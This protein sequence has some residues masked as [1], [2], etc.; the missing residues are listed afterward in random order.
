MEEVNPAGCMHTRANNREGEG[1]VEERLDRFFGAAN[2]IL[3]HPR[4]RVIYKE[5]QTSDHY[6]IVLNSNPEVRK[7]RKRFYFDQR[8]LQWREVSDV[9]EKGWMQAQAGTYMHQVCSKIKTCRVALLKWSKG[10]LINSSKQIKELKM[11]LEELKM[12]LEELSQQKGNRDWH[13]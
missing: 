8:W 4:A 11:K 3:Q 12:K 10:L 1:F 6:L 2:W 5:K 13:T 9:V 7:V